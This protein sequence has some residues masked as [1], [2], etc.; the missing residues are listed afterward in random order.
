M[1]RTR[2]VVSLVAA[3][4]LVIACAPVG[5]MPTWTYTPGGA[6]GADATP[7]TTPAASV[8][9]TAGEILGTLEVTS[10]D[11]GFEP[12]VLTVEKAGRYEVTL[13]N[14]GVLPHDITF[15]GG[16]TGVAMAGASVT[17]TVDVPESGITFICSVPG[18]ADAGMT[19]SITVQQS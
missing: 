15:S 18:H 19:G 9:A 12:R 11:L 13:M 5:H 10:V 14:A 7:A 17:V 8:D 3:A 1:L 4:V 6:N 2:L 16:Q